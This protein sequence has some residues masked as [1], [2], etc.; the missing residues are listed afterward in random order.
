MKAKPR[1]TRLRPLVLCLLGLSTVA[2]AQLGLP[3]AVTDRVD[4][5]ID[6]VERVHRDTLP[7]D[8]TSALERRLTAALPEQLPDTLRPPAEPLDA[9]P[10][11]V[12]ILDSRGATLFMD[13]EVEDGWRAV[14]H[15]WLLMLAPGELALLEPLNVEI[16]EQKRLPKL[17]LEMVRFRVPA[18][19]DSYA[20]LQNTLP[21]DLAERLD[22][23]HIYNPQAANPSSESAERPRKPLCEQPVKVGMVDTAI[24]TEHPGLIN[25][26]IVERNF[27]PDPE[28]TDEKGPPTGH[29]TAVAG[30]MLGIIDETPARLPGATLYNASVFYSRNQYAQGATMMHL[31]SGLEWLIGQEV[32]VIN[33]SLTGPDN[34][35]LATVMERLTA[36]GIAVV[37]AAGNEGPAAP[38]LYPAAYSGVIASTAVDADGQVYRWANRGEHIDFA[39]P[40]VSVRTTRGTGEFGHESGTSMAA[41][42]VTAHVACALAKQLASSGNVVQYLAGQAKDLGEAGRDPIFGHGL[43]Q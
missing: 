3:S 20:A 41:P 38:P 31:V 18:R 19:L 6:S 4:R 2:Q 29:G 33:M 34:R 10:S 7:A 16:L 26:R 22:R 1:P 14:Q 36:G 39:G 9:L 24:A 40:G 15:E 27:L 30:L 35:V 23:N 21:A 28:G 42:T 37:A 12:P 32:S 43:L 5:S 8:V 25:S 13:V 17:G 11:R